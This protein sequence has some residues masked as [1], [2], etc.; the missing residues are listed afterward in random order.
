MDPLYLGISTLL[1]NTRFCGIA[2]QL[3]VGE[4]MQCWEIFSVWKLS[5]FLDQGLVTAIH[6]TICHEV[7]LNIHLLAQ[8]TPKGILFYKL[9]PWTAGDVLHSGWN[10][11]D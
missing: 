8:C 9:A 6:I 5:D 7:T 10:T 3:L 2:N 1:N 4:V 11:N